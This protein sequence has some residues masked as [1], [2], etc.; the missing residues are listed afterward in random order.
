MRFVGKE[1]TWLWSKETDQQECTITSSWVPAKNIKVEG[2]AA[3]R[4]RMT[5]KKGLG[6]DGPMASDKEVTCDPRCS[7]NMSFDPFLV[8][9]LK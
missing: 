3:C 6:R 4:H 8:I 1:S 9:I 5:H 2:N 7:V